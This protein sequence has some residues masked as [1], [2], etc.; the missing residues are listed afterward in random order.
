MIKYIIFIVFFSNNILANNNDIINY[1]Q[2]ENRDDFESYYGTNSL[3][4]VDIILKELKNSKDLSVFKKLKLVNELFNKFTYIPD[5]THWRLDNYWA[6]ALDLI[7][8]NAGD[9]EDFALAKYIALVSLGV[10]QEKFKLMRYTNYKNRL[11]ESN[12][13]IV[14]VYFHKPN[15][16]AIILDKV[17]SKLRHIKSNNLEQVK[18]IHDAGLWNKFFNFT[19]KKILT[20]NG[21]ELSK[22]LQLNASLKTENQWKRIFKF[23]IQRYNFDKLNTKQRKALLDYLV[24]NSIDLSLSELAEYF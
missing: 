17:N 6:S 5:K 3:K 13:Y 1:F 19:P 18:L 12:E 7:G 4:R 14:L 23:K 16:R 15:K 20:N 24:Y 11:D 8:T 21:K 9:S 22:I 10:E 2:P